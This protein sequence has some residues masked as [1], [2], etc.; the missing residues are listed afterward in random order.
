M[1]SV[2]CHFRLYDS[3]PPP[4]FSEAYRIDMT[5]LRLLQKRLGSRLHAKLP[6]G[7]DQEPMQSGAMVRLSA[8]S[9]VFK[10]LKRPQID[11]DC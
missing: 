7:A 9:S 3:P 11:K 6:V 8:Y 1:G 2:A 10:A 5:K 4:S